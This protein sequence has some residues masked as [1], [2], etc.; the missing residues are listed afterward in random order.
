MNCTHCST[1]VERAL[2]EQPGVATVTVDLTTG[3]ARV[4]G[5]DLNAAALIA[6]I[7]ALGFTASETGN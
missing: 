1:S 7:E 6:A 5:R 4:G 2:T 3:R